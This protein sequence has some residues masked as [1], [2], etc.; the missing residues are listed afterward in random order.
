MIDL[1]PKRNC[2]T[3]DVARSLSSSVLWFCRL[4]GS[5]SP[6]F[7]FMSARARESD[8]AVG[9]N[10]SFRDEAAES[11]LHLIV[12]HKV[13]FFL[14]YKLFFTIQLQPGQIYSLLSLCIYDLCQNSNNM[15]IS[16]FF[17]FTAEQTLKIYTS[18]S[19]QLGSCCKIQS[20]TTWSSTAT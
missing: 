2:L 19:S 3:V 14:H 6:P 13:L 10:V 9:W 20:I 12:W 4:H 8:E 5:F 1:L 11:L 7:R 15:L 17:L 16:T 18:L